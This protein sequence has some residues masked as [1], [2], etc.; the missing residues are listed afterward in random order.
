MTF[1]TRLKQARKAKG[2]TQR[3][4]ADMIGAKNSSV[5]NWEKDLVMPYPDTI[6][7]ICWALG[8]DANYFFGDDKKEEQES[9]I[10]V[11]STQEMTSMYDSLDNHGKEIVIA[12]LRLEAKRMEEQHEKET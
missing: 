12:V 1:G 11:M 7:S 8:V 9:Q 6:G 10:R 2:L 5:C 4:L 3:K